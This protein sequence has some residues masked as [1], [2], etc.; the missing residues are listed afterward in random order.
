MKKIRKSTGPNHLTVYANSNPLEN[1]KSFRDHNGGL[2][3]RELRNHIFDTQG[4][5]CAYCEA[6]VNDEPESRRG[7]EHFHPKRDRSN[8]GKNWSLDWRNVFGVCTGGNYSDKQIHP[9]PRNLSCDSH[10][11]HHK[12]LDN[13]EGYILNP[14][15][16]INAPC[17]FALNKGTGALEVDESA[18][19]KVSFLENNFDSTSDLVSSTIRI[20]NLNCDRLSQQRRKILINYEQQLK[21]GKLMNDRN[22]HSK[23]AF[24]WFAKEWPSFFSTRRILLGKYAEDYLNSILYDG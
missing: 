18:C 22:I 13:P 21:K 23:I 5:L 8:P 19:E 6:Q 24:R 1:W 12:K 3:Y 20:L 16:I 10:K 15:D 17:L 11:E 4:G 14:L 2:S 7:I 9:L